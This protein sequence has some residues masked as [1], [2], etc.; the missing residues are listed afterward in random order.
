M[1][2]ARLAVCLY[3]AMMFAGNAVAQ[4]WPARPIK[5]VVPSGPGLGADILAQL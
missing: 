4:E 1:K 2:L 5:L 3:V